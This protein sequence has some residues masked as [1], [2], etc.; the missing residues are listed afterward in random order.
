MSAIVR[1]TLPGKFLPGRELLAQVLTNRVGTGP[2]GVR[3]EKSIHRMIFNKRRGIRMK[4][5]RKA[6][7]NY[8]V[9]AAGLVELNLG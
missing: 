4:F 3:A 9:D 5:L 6:Q 1:E 2:A 8:C 7:H